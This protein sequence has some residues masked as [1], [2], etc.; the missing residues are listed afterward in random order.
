MSG[1]RKDELLAQKRFN[2]ESAVI[3]CQ[4]VVKDNEHMCNH[5]QEGWGP[6]SKCV[7][8]AGGEGYSR[9]C[10]NCI[11]NGEYERCSFWQAEQDPA[12]LGIQNRATN[13]ISPQSQRERPMKHGQI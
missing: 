3:F 4:G 8:L 10:A 13:G 1:R 7:Q 9:A 2:V 12:T 11:W 6:W 5:C